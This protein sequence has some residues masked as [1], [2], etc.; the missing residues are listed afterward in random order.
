MERGGYRSLEVWQRSRALAIDVFRQTQHGLLSREWG[1]RDQMRR[2]AVSAPS[3]IA[4]GTE[5]GSNRDCAR[6]L[7][8]A[9]G[10]LAELAT[11]A[12][13]ADSVGL[14]DSA[15]AS[16]WQDECRRLSGMLRRLIDARLHA[17]ER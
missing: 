16:Q 17:A 4:E 14:L 8:V 1:L 5:R 2:A 6:F 9:K 11:Q 12:D 7:W 13:I 10:S 3:N 15:T